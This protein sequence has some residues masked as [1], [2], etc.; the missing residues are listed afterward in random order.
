[1]KHMSL[2]AH[3]NQDIVIESERI[4]L[5]DEACKNM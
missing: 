2:Q 3:E 1:M 5:K 4:Y